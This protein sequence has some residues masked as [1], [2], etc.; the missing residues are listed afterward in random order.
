MPSNREVLEF[1]VKLDPK[2]AIRESNRLEKSWKELMKLP[3]KFSKANEDSVRGVAKNLG[4]LR[5][6]IADTN[7]TFRQASRNPFLSEDLKQHTKRVINTK[8][9]YEG[10]TAA[11]RK[12]NK[13][14]KNLKDSFKKAEESGDKGS[15]GNLEKALKQNLKDQTQVIASY[16][17][18]IKDAVKIP[19]AAK[20]AAMESAKI[21]KEVKDSLEEFEGRAGKR[22][23]E[24]RK[25]L[26]G[27]GGEDMAKEFGDSLEGVFESLS[28][29]SASGFAS[30]LLKGLGS[31]GKG[32]AG[33]GARA[34]GK[35]AITGGKEAGM[36]A[37][38]M[39]G[40]GAG[41]GKVVN[42]LAKVGPIVGMASAAIMALV[43]LF[44]DA[45][46][47][48]KEFNKAVL[49]GA[50]T[51]EFLA[52][53]GGR[54]LTSFN[55]LKST[56]KELRD[57]AFDFSTNLE[58]GITSKEH[59]AFVGTLT[60]EGVSLLSIAEEAKASKKSVEDFAKSLITSGVV[61]SRS[62]GVSLEEI[63]TVQ[64]Q[65]MQDLGS[66]SE[67][68][69]K[70]FAAMDDIMSGSG[71]AA[72]KFF[73]IV[74][75]LSTDM[76]LFNLRMGEAAKLLKLVSKSMN[77]KQA[78]KFIQTLGGHFKGQDFRGRI[79]S[80][81]LGGGAKATSKNLRG[82]F[83]TK[84]TGLLNE[85]Q[86]KGIDPAALREAISKGG[87]DLTGF[88]AKNQDKLN[89]GMRSEILDASKQSARLASG[90]KGNLLDTAA[91]LK[92]A[93]PL[94][95]LKQVDSIAKNFFGKTSDK[96]SGM[97]MFA[98]TSL[99][100]GVT[101]EMLD[102]ISKFRK[103]MDQMR[104]DLAENLTKGKVTEED[105]KTLQRLGI[106]ETDTEAAKKV[107]GT[108]DEQ[109][110]A[111][112]SDDQQRIAMHGKEMTDY[113]KEQTSLTQTVTD[114]IQ[115]LIDF[116]MNKYYNLIMGIYD[117]ITSLPFFKDATK[118]SVTKYGTAEMQALY[119][120][121]GGDENI[122]RD[123]L[124]KTKGYQDLQSQI[125][126]SPENE[127]EA[128]KRDAAV[129]KV[130]QGMNDP[131]RDL[132]TTRDLV[133]RANLK[134]SSKVDAILQGTSSGKSLSEAIEAAGVSAEDRQRI[135]DRGLDTLGA[136]SLTK[137]MGQPMMTDGKA[138]AATKPS[139]Q[140]PPAPEA[141]KTAEETKVATEATTAAI[142][143]MTDKTTKQGVK[144]NKPF[145]KGEV[146]NTVTDSTL[147][148]MRT[149]LYEYYL[150]KDVPLQDMAK[151]IQAGLDPKAVGDKLVA[152]LKNPGDFD[153]TKTLM[154][155]ANAEGGTVMRPAPG[156]AFA[157]VAPGEKI[158]PK[159]GGGGGGGGS[160]TINV[161][162]GD[163]MLG[164]IIEGK[165]KEG[166]EIWSRR[167][168]RRMLGHA[169]N[170]PPE[171]RELPKAR[172]PRDRPSLP[173]RCGNPSWGGP[174]G[175]PDH[176]PF[177]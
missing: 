92:Q 155:S 105:K 70:Q 99:P 40:M 131:S 169:Q 91:A 107:L 115:I 161:N 175:F 20:A 12:L 129:N 108:S 94:A 153:A 58:L 29:K 34:A 3:K 117:A 24:L 163:R 67:T 41:V 10:M 32:L 146:G 120:Q 87:E 61:Y 130:L 43:K 160:T 82:E 127:E 157:S 71:I 7:K 55:E 170:Q 90:D 64:S 116:L 44:I 86:G 101:E 4:T 171:P 62:F 166:F 121:S 106:S 74:R 22:A 83:D 149:A 17:K 85:A 72:N 69:S 84:L 78:E 140:P 138:G 126:K 88:M 135:A 145:L 73:G 162:V 134:D 132:N 33:A 150:Y 26:L 37:K 48:A 103:G 36:M 38:A 16:R 53:S 6:S 27:Y 21:L 39:G 54:S 113:A 50:S 57:S 80:T 152:G 104:A 151:A 15:A 65:V 13:E 125:R 5:R 47:Q 49:Q 8:K 77:A 28:S 168:A 1:A 93:G 19:K 66:S 11:L 110:F 174:S 122:Y 68:V 144:I 109:I 100:G 79:Q 159:G 133:G 167:Q 25:E 139:E 136:S 30:N 42:L 114:K 75:N 9:E 35:T 154:A 128:K 60:K 176:V 111:S 165:V 112:L 23:S 63:A 137:L 52:K 95:T 59:E 102:E 14:R 172:R 177:G 141:Q 96:L 56:M 156:E 46:A 45:E 98:M 143:D 97:D 119:S 142:E 148:A 81:L 158:I 31:V 173:A 89:S 51:T 124:T 2:E 123:K 164:E 118:S 18:A 147:D 76:S